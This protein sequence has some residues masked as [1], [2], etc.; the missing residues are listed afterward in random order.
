MGLLSSIE[1]YFIYAPQKSLVTTSAEHGLEFESIYFV[2]SD[3]V[4]LHGWWVPVPHARATVLL[5]HGNSGNVSYQ[6]DQIKAFHQLSLHVFTF[7]YRGFGQ[8]DGQPSEDG[9]Y[10][11]GKAAWSY[12]VEQKHILPEH[13]IIFG[14][15]L[16]GGVAAWLSKEVKAGAVILQATFTTMKQIAK[17]FY[18]YFPLRKIMRSRY[19]NLAHIAQANCPVLVIHSPDDEVVPFEHGKRVFE[20]AKSPKEFLQVRYGHD[21]AIHSPNYLSGIKAFL[22]KYLPVSFPKSTPV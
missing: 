19:D 1:R 20:A 2:A 11:D 5:C 7:D 3:G 22:D 15:S 13:I 16:G 17:C 9:L 4:K 18:P 12:L 8:S 6:L 14:H 21:D 10:R